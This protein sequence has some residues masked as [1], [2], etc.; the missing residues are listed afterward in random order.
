M[1]NQQRANVALNLSYVLHERSDSDA[2]RQYV[3][4][5]EVEQRRCS[6]A[7]RDIGRLSDGELRSRLIVLDDA[8]N[9]SSREPTG[10]QII[11]VDVGAGQLFPRLLQVAGIVRPGTPTFGS[12]LDGSH[13]GDE[14]PLIFF[15]APAALNTP[16][17]PVESDVPLL[18]ATAVL[19]PGSASILLRVASLDHDGETGGPD[20]QR[21]AHLAEAVI[22]EFPLQWWCERPLWAR[23]VQESLPEFQATGNGTTA[24]GR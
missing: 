9:S 10:V 7:I 15:G 19:R 5:R 24:C 11:S 14:Q 23:P 1:E 3:R 4:A 17:L 18:F 2:A 13:T 12:L 6:K 8:E 21:A 20:W 16:A 22:R